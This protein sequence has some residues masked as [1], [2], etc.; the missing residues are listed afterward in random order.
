MSEPRRPVST[1]RIVLIGSG[2]T[3][4]AMVKTHRAVLAS[5]GSGPAVMLDTPYG[6]QV[7]ADDLTQRTIRYFADSVGHTVRAARWRSRDDAGHD[8]ALAEVSQA[9]WLFAG[10]G[11]PTYALSQWRD[12]PMTGAISDVVRRGGTVTLGSAAAVT[13]GRWAVPVYEIYKVGADP[14][15]AEGLDLLAEFLDLKL[16]VIP[17]FDN[18]EGGTYDTRFCYLGLERLT[19]ME[20]QLD[21]DAA[22]LGI[23][24]H[25]AL[26]IDLGAEQVDVTGTGGVTVRRDGSTH[27][28]PA[29][30]TMTIAEFTAAFTTDRAA[31]SGSSP[32]ANAARGAAE[33]S[34]TEAAAVTG[35]G[36]SDAPHPSL[37]ADVAAQ[38]DAFDRALEEQDADAAVAAVL[39]VDD[40]IQAWSADTLQSD[41]IDRARRQ[42]RAMVVRLGE[43]ARVGTTDP[44]TIV[45]PL[46]EPLLEARAA[47]REQKNYATSDL[48]RDVLGAG[49][50]EVQDTAE[51]VTWSF[52]PNPDDTKDAQGTNAD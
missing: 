3:A 29:G 50:V 23:D 45:A 36:D 1:G 4:P 20:N 12:T 2:E 16:A 7:N 5:A 43:L 11:S 24:E 47:A 46:V 18:A 30:T 27:V 10:P 40:A 25:T 19:T 9:S 21:E 14:E 8:H 51:G 42:L 38:R 6:F 37:E 31:P 26:L 48:I 17:H 32:T 34:P 41:A 44:A 39:A 13:A 28:I 49:G 52:A 22:V 35:V 33:P 15:W